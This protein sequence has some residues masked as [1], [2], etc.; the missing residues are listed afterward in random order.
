VGTQPAAILQFTVVDRLGNTVNATV[1]C[2]KVHILT[3]R[4]HLAGQEERVKKAISDPE[5]VYEGNTPDS[6]EFWGKP[7]PSNGFQ[8]GGVRVVAVVKYL[9]SGNGILKTAYTTAGSMT[10]GNQLWP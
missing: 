10:P 1:Q 8:W 9:A 4:P 7:D 5:R 2:W 3:Q 6:K